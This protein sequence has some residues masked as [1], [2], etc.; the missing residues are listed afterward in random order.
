MKVTKSVAWKV[1]P[2]DVIVTSNKGGAVRAEHMVTPT[3]FTFSP[4]VNQQGEVISDDVKE[5][6]LVF[7]WYYV[8]YGVTGQA[9]T[10]LVGTGQTID[11]NTNT[12]I[13]TTPQQ[14]GAV[15]QSTNVY[16]EVYLLGA[17]HLVNGSYVRTI[18]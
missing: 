1:P 6:N 8:K 5:A 13:N 3:N 16:C 4:I 18:D 15:K 2:I 17:Y 9:V 10:Q 11:I 14:E 12:L 7:K